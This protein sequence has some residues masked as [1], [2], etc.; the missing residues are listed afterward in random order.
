M[1][2]G[3]LTIYSASAGSGKTHQLAGIYLE[4]LFRSKLSYRKILAVTFTHKATA[5]MKGRI[6]DELNKLAVGDNSKYLDDLVRLTS[7]SEDTIRREAKEILYSILHDFSRFSVSTIDSFYQKIVRAFARD[8]GL[9]SGFDIEIDHTNILAVAVDR[10]IASAASDLTIKNWLLD[11]ASA[12][13]E[14]G[15]TWDLRKSITVLAGELFNEKFKL[16]SQDEKQKLQDKELLKSYIKEMRSI[17]SSF[18][19]VLKEKGLKSLNIID[20]YNLSDDMF[21]QK[22]KGVASYIRSV[23]KGEIRLPNSYV[24]AAL[25]NPPR[26]SSGEPAAPL[27]EAIREGLGESVGEVVKYFDENIVFYKTAD[28]ILSY[29]YILGILSDVLNQVHQITRDE[30]IFLLSDAGELISMITEKDQTPFIYEKVGNTFE[31]YMIDEFQDTSVIQWKNFRQLIDNSMAQGFENLVVGDIKQSIYRWRNSDWRTL[32]DLK[33][34]IDNI[35]YISRP[36]NTNYRSCS[37]IIR[38]NNSIFSIIPYQI[39][40]GLSENKTVTDFREL[41]SEAVQIDP[42]KKENGYVRIEFIENSEESSWQAEVLN[43]LPSVIE[44]IQDRGFRA[45]DIGILV[46]DNK[47]GALILR[48]II[49]YSASCSIEKRERYNY[50]IVS[51]ESLL[52]ANSP[53]VNFIIAV[54]KVL[55]NP[56]DMIARALML[57]FFLLATGKENAGDTPLVG[58]ELVEF[59]AGFF[60]EDFEEFLS[61]IRYLTLW[62]ITEKTIGFFGLGN[63]SYNVAFLNS[64]Q[65][66]VITHASVRNP[67]ISSFLEWWESE[68]IKKSISVPEQQDSMKVLTIHKS[69]GLEF[70]IVILPFLSW[71]LDHKIFHSNILW[72]KPDY[73]PFNKLGIVP[74]RYKGELAETIFADQYLEEKYSAYL[75]NINLLYVAF[76][77]AVNAIIGFAPDQPRTENRIASVIRDAIIFKGT[78]PDG[79]DTFLHN[80]Y[81]PGSRIFELGFLK[82]FHKENETSGGLRI[83]NYPVN[84]NAGSLK[85]KLH[86]EDYFSADKSGAREKIN[87]GKMMHEIFGEIITSDDVALVVRKKVLEGVINESEGIMITGKVKSLINQ[88]V[89]RDWFDKGNEVLNEASVL[90]PDSTTK[91]PDRIIIREGRTSI[92]DFKFGAENQSHLNQ[93][94]QY[95]KMLGGMGYNVTE[96]YLWYVD[97]DKIVSA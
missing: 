72:A 53:A 15:K 28:V 52:L 95:R 22:G 36:L 75:D 61:S 59:S 85:L 49:D 71:N 7:K 19:T 27:A 12:N 2:V 24:R 66:I 92:I 51:G 4:K 74:V 5:E 34:E 94:R 18:S 38:F 86:W 13:I 87:Y 63:Y 48:E 25:G 45:S 84:D 50:N 8:I 44:S 65:D 89:A 6:L 21:F 68:G 78:H 77:R 10:M 82:G 58:D 67:G 76:T 9:H 39:D 41:F 88:P 81:D 1:G 62:N 80:H 57:R 47:E 42:G 29:I 91:R 30:N 64:F 56:G 70:G 54:L 96:A 17:K 40:A 83:D 20:L 79:S 35:R 23:S 73:H 93:I 14:E 3:T 46:R 90:M 97:D 16:L 60:P 55:D 26:W 69:K 31:N 11:F 32:R 43:R 33:K 37:D